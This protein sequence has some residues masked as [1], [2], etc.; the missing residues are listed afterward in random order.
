MIP[1]KTHALKGGQG[2]KRLW[3]LQDDWEKKE[4]TKLLLSSAR[5]KGRRNEGKEGR[6]V[7]GES[8][9]TAHKS[10]EAPQLIAQRK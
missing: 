10:D 1:R 4:K 5:K 8:G 9:G 6:R 2:G 3:D 7:G